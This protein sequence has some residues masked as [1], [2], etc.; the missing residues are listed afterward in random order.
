MNPT[1]EQ[2]RADQATFGRGMRTD[3]VGQPRKKFVAKGHD[4]LLERLQMS[5]QEIQITTVNGDEGAY[6]GF[7]HKRDKWTVTLKLHDGRL[8]IIYKH[9]IEAILFTEAN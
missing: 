4:A 6:A 3:V 2:I 5:S 8:A 7:I 1:Q 9:A